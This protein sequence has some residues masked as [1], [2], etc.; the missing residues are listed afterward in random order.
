L[1]L[2]L[3][4]GLHTVL[5]PLVCV[6]T[7]M[8]S[9]QVLDVRFTDAYVALAIIAALLCWISMRPRET[10][11]M[12]P[13]LS[14]AAVW[15]SIVVA[16]V[17]VMGVLLL[18]GYLTKTSDL[19]SRRAL[20]MWALMTP[21]IIGVTSLVLRYMLRAFLLSSDGARRA[22]IVGV[23][24]MS[25]DLARN[26]EERPE[27]GLKLACFFDERSID[28]TA[29]FIGAS[30]IGFDLRRRYADLRR[31]V[32]ERHV[33]VVFVAL[34]IEQDQ[35]QAILNDLR[36]T[37]AS[38]YLIPDISI[39]DLI[40]SRSDDVSG[41]PVIA[42]CESPF[43]GVRGLIKRTTDIVLTSLLLLLMLPIMVL[44]AITLMLTSRG[45]VIFKQDRYGLDGQRIV[46][47]KFRT[48]TVTENKGSIEQATRNDPRVTP[49][50]RFLR[51]TS[52]DE[53]PQLINVLQGRMSL[54]GPRPHAVAHNEQY[55]KLISGYMVRHK[56]A[57]GI[58]G[59]AQ[60]NGCR[61]ETT[62]LEEMERR[63]AYDLD[64][65]RQW[66]W[67]LDMKILLST[68]PLLFRD[69]HAF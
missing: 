66:C 53:L 58:T 27:L 13:H 7:L 49:F 51:R 39:F 65:L 10:R 5:A 45:S 61:G 24:Q 43:N 14:A 59:L 56:V 48:M 67:Q 34:Q 3:L 46:V 64:Y 35:T 69:K 2:A 29:G 40:Q 42:L 60:I 37:T 22:V 68:C 32:N 54:V 31:Y 15:S 25:L 36:D 8:I 28:R 55:R 38:V 18:I 11:S 30:R 6:L 62:T 26:L 63:V 16:W 57:P 12:Q 9:T 23:T 17:G 21:P 47:Y 44:I 50:G 41:V 52:L 19:F 4:T 33:D 20:F 1:Q